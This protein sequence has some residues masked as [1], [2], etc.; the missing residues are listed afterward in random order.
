MNERE[1]KK[2]RQAEKEL[3]TAP[4]KRAAKLAEKIVKWK[5]D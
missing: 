2:L 5:S 3:L 4:P 1:F